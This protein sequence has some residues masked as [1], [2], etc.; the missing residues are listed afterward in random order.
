MWG[1]MGECMNVAGHSAVVHWVSNSILRLVIAHAT[2]IIL[3]PIR[4][5]DKP[6]YGGQLHGTSHAPNLHRYKSYT[7]YKPNVFGNCFGN[8][9]IQFKKL[10]TSWHVSCKRKAN[11]TEAIPV[12]EQHRG[13]AGS[14]CGLC[15]LDPEFCNHLHGS[16]WR[17]R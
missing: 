3:Q 10:S 4:L 6:W 17:L 13:P 5:W 12:A 9:C 7:S 11:S 8:L 2:L 1:P 16:L 14:C 15:S